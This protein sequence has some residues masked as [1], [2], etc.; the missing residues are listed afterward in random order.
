MAQYIDAEIVF[1]CLLAGSVGFF[2]MKMFLL[3]FAAV[4]GETTSRQFF[5]P[6]TTQTGSPEAIPEPPKEKGQ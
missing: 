6:V 2:A 4:A 1:L 5:P 3:R